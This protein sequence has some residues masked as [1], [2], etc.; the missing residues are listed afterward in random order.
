MT[1]YLADALFGAV[2]G[3]LVFVVFLTLGLGVSAGLKA[4]NRTAAKLPKT[5][6]E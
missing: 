2:L 1:D 6:G 5:R 3:A 4:I